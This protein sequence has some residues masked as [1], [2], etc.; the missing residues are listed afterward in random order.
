VTASARP[1]RGF[2]G[3]T[4]AVYDASPGKGGHV[5]IGGGVITLIIIILLLIWLF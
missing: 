5:Y 2:S 3:A 4:S 1:R